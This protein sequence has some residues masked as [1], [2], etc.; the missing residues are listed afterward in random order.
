MHNSVDIVCLA[1]PSWD[2][3]Y[4]KSTV[5][6][7]KGLAVRNRVLY[8]EYPFTA[9]DLLKKRSSTSI[10]P[11]TRLLGLTPRLRQ[12]DAQLGSSLNVLT[13]PPVAPANGLPPGQVFETA[14]KMNSRIVGRAVKKAMKQLGMHRPVVVNALNPTYGWALTGQ[15]NESQTIYYCY[16][17]IAGQSWNARHGLHYED[18]YLPSVTTVI[19]TSET[20]LKTKSRLNASAHLIPNGVDYELF[21]N[22]QIIERPAGSRPVVGYVGSL[23]D[24]LDYELLTSIAEG[25]PDLE[26]LFVGPILDPACTTLSLLE[27]VRMVGPAARYED[28]PEWLSQ[29]DVGLIPFVK[30]E[31]TANI[32]PMKINEY[33]A[34]GKPVVRTRFADLPSFDTM[35]DVADTAGEFLLA[36]RNACADNSSE[37]VSIRK[38]FAALNSWESRV[39]LFENVIHQYRDAELGAEA[40]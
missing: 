32:Y 6:L 9:K 4:M 25:A 22:A 17:E 14:I 3:P 29:M 12:P 2:G 26:F 33:L 23:D 28:L 21:A 15:L 37:V 34:A 36:I 31:F 27:N 10:V 19:T 18:L 1:L 7:M 38:A 8:V 5:Q 20:L 35:V 13:V 11:K 39:V 16:D 40:A 24:R 30:N